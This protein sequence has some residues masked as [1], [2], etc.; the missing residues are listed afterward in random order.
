MALMSGIEMP[1]VALRSQVASAIDI[2]VQLGRFHDGSRRILEIAE[3]LGLDDAG[4]HDVRSIYAF[5]FTGKTP[6]GGVAGQLERTERRPSFL[7]EVEQ[8]GYGDRVRL[9][10]TLF[11]GV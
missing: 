9:T 11:E 7:S 10:R 2:V 3:V 4:R 8:K 1:L 6:T 5:A